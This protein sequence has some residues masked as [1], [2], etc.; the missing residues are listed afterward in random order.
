MYNHAQGGDLQISPHAQ[1]IFDFIAQVD[2]SMITSAQ[3]AKIKWVRLLQTQNQVRRD[4]G[5][6]VVEGVRLVEEA[7]AA[8]W[9]ARLLLHTGDLNER[10]LEIVDGFIRR[11]TP[12]EQVTPQVMRSASDTQTP[13]GILAVLATTPQ[14]IPDRPDFA[15]IPDGIRDPGNLGSV[16]RTAAA[17]GVDVVLVPEGGVDIYSPKVVRAAMGAHFHVPVQVLTWEAIRDL[18]QRFK[19]KVYLAEA[20]GAEMYTQVDLKKPVALVIGGEAAGAGDAAKLLAQGRLRIPMPGGME[21]LNAAA[22]AAIILYEVVRQ[23]T[24]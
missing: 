19:L 4:E 14:P 2:A 11:Q 24:L 15:L 18:V 16:L 6:F 7:L 20:G 9:P 12:V 23:R 5:V 3:N 13:Q 10:G 22:A 1:P 21:S 8:G 17:A